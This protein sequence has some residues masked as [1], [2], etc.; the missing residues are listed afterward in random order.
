[1]YSFPHAP[2]RSACTHGIKTTRMALLP[3]TPLKVKFRELP[4]WEISEDD[5]LRLRQLHLD[6]GSLAVQPGAEA[7]F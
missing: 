2:H 5:F 1:M 3:R 4:Y 7:Q 6:L